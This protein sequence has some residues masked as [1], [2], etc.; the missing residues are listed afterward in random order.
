MTKAKTKSR[1]ARKSKQA[2][3]PKVDLYQ[4]VTDSIIASIERGVPAWRKPWAAPGGA[5]NDGV[6]FPR[7][8]NGQRYTG[9]NVLLLWSAA[10][11]RGFQNATWMTFNQAK[12]LGGAV[13]KGEKGEGI[14]YASKFLKEIEDPKTGDTKKVPI[15]FLKGYT[16][17]NVEQIDGLPE[18]FYNTAEPAPAAEIEKI[19]LERIAAADSFFLKLPGDVRHGG[20]QAFYTI[21][22]DYIQVPHFDAFESAEAYYSTLGHEYVHWTRHPS[23]LDRDYGRKKWGDEGYA[24]EELVAELGA[25]FLS[26]VLGISLEV[27]EDHAAYLASWLEVLQ[28]DKRFIFTAASA[29]QKAV[30]FLQAGGVAQA[31][32]D[33]ADV[34]AAAAEAD[35]DNVIQ[36][37]RAA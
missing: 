25:A 13:R 24:R 14:I 1:P 36:F 9:V 3:G 26:A 4:K 10:I 6:I 2:A 30:D 16:V 27:R 7:R 37:A 15:P 23:R 33:E 29:A 20:N 34:I 22:A 11:E 35:A 31:A 12:D 5:F 28:N 17:F 21:G 32:D 18:R 8:V 19:K